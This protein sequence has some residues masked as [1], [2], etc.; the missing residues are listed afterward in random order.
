M[1]NCTSNS[2]QS[3]NAVAQEPGYGLTL[4]DDRQTPCPSLVP[5]EVQHNRIASWLRRTPNLNKPLPP[6]PVEV[7]LSEQSPGE[8]LADDSKKAVESSPC[9]VCSFDEERLWSPTKWR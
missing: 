9:E 7:G 3:D 8:W 6:L 4:A 5:S 2:S 1:G